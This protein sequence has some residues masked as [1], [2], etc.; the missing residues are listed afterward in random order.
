[1]NL[2]TL[3][4]APL[5]NANFGK[6]LH[7]AH[8]TL[9]W[10]YGEN[11]NSQATINCLS[12][13]QWVCLDTFDNMDYGH[14]THRYRETSLWFCEQYSIRYLS[15]NRI[16]WGCTYVFDLLISNPKNSKLYQVIHVY[17]VQPTVDWIY[18]VSFGIFWNSCITW[19]YPWKNQQLIQIGVSRFWWSNGCVLINKNNK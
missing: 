10:W 12:S 19:L 17:L 14:P 1:M 2:K 16:S 18:N 11:F 8:C 5:K 6:C 3:L 13:T 4:Q 15:E 7:S 9:T